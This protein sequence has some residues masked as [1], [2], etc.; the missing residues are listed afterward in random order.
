MLSSLSR[1]NFPSTA[2]QSSIPPIPAMRGYI[3]ES[4][5]GEMGEKNGQMDELKGLI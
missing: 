4:N 5:A 1:F 2:G 3:A